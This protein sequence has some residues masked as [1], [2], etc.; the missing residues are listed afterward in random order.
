MHAAHL[1]GERAIPVLEFVQEVEHRLLLALVAERDLAQATRVHVAHAVQNN[2][3]NRKHHQ[4]RHP[5]SP[6]RTLLLNRTTDLYEY[7]YVTR[8]RTNARP[9]V[10]MCGRELISSHDLAARRLKCFVQLSIGIAEELPSL[11]ALFE[12]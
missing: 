4:H 1:V 6:C 8:Y 11:S 10:Y 2:T 3:R 7:I 12:N 9:R 5:I